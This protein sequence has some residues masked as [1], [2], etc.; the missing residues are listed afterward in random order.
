MPPKSLIFAGAIFGDWRVTCRKL[1]HISTG[2]YLSNTSTSNFSSLGFAFNRFMP[3]EV[4]FLI[5]V[6]ISELSPSELQHYQGYRAFRLKNFYYFASASLHHNTSFILQL[7]M[8]TFSC[9]KFQFDTD[10]L[11]F[12]VNQIEL[13]AA[14][15]ID[16]QIRSETKLWFVGCH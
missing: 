8:L 10:F 6:L 1:C 5:R 14:L 16:C 4:F 11:V 3:K 15:Y 9:I 13:K 2:Y 12:I 7:V